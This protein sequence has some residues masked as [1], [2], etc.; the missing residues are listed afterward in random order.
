MKKLT[1]QLLTLIIAITVFSATSV[2]AQTR[3]T[4]N[5]QGTATLSGTAK[6]KSQLSGI[7]SGK[8]FAT[9][10]IKVTK[11]G[12]LKYE[13][14]RGNEFLSSGHTTGS[15]ITLNSDGRSNYTITF[16][17]EEDKAKQISAAIT[18]SGG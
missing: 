11:G 9:A 16:I 2:F 4:F 17:N 3:I 8:D 13:I 1:L 14:R 10:N 12:K 7:I 15:N 5:S 18:K 6:P